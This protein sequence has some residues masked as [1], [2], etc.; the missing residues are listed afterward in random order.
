MKAFGGMADSGATRIA[1]HPILEPLPAVAS[2]TFRFDGRDV[3]GREGEP[4]AVSLLAAG[5]RIFRTMPRFGDARGGYCLVG[6]CADC[7]VI[8]DGVPSVR[9]CVTPVRAGLDVR[10]QHGL[11]EHDEDFAP[12]PSR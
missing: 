3:E 2:V 9:A 4:I 11:G 10:T 7:M 5:V 12:D 8:V 1:T 6:R